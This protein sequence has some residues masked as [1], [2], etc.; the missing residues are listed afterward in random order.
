MPDL[1]LAADSVLSFVHGIALMQ[2]LTRDPE[3]LERQLV[4]LKRIFA[5][6]VFHA[7]NAP[8]GKP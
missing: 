3:L 6:A 8:G 5:L 7:A 1:D 2:R 4:Y